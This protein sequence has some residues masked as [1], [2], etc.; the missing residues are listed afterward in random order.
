MSTLFDDVQ[1]WF[2]S[3]S[4]KASPLDEPNAL[5]MGFVGDESRWQCFAKV[6]EEQ[7]HLL[8]YSVAP[9]N[10]PPEKRSAVSE[11][12]TRANYG[13]MIGNFELDYSDGEIRYKTSV[14]VEDSSYSPELFRNMVYANVLTMDRY[15]PGILA[16]I[17]GD[18]SAEEALTKVEA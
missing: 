2:E 9:V 11:Y 10:A 13:L 14:D 15:I 12:I 4:W 8:F 3:D 6:R 16:I 1:A 5:V 7:K 18:R 17:H